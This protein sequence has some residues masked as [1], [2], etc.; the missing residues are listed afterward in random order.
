MATGRALT[1]IGDALGKPSSSI[2]SHIKPY[3]GIRPRR[4]CRSRLALT[5]SEREEISRGLAADRT[6]R[7]ISLQLGRSPST[8]SREIARNGERRRYR[9]AEA[10]QRAWK[11]ALRPKQCKLVTN[12]RLRDMVAE[13]L[14][15]DSLILTVNRC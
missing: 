15:N 6:M 2:W 11:A 1:S 7:E 12:E 14:Q 13:K 3:G 10:D 8:V 4:R 9:A 5:L